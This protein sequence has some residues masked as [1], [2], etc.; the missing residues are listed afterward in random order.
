VS[1]LIKEFYDAIETVDRINN[2]KEKARE[3]INSQKSTIKDFYRE[4]IYALERKRDEELSDLDE[5]KEAQLTALESKGSSFYATITKMERIIKFIHLYVSQGPV[6]TAEVPT[7]SYSTNRD[8]EGNYL[9]GSDRR[10]VIVKPVETIRNDQYNQIHLYII[11]NKKPVNKFSLVIRGNCSLQG[12]DSW[13]R[14]WGRIAIALKD[15]PS[16]K[17]LLGYMKRN[18]G[19]IK[20]KIDMVLLDQLQAEYETSVA[21][22]ARPVWKTFYFERRMYHY[23][24]GVTI[25][26]YKDYQ[27]LYAQSKEN[28]KDLPLL[29]GTVQSDEGKH[30]LEFL[31]K[32]Y[33][34]SPEHGKSSPQMFEG[35]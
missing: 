8:D 19:K 26:E 14:S 9:F 28:F 24:H 23:K 34:N 31:L 12:D 5:K 16:E 32:S 1:N 25:G 33:R 2:E 7:V 17:V 21:L 27:A 11:P 10:E 18:L 15:A 35:V 30:A 6:I 13:G 20:G 3:A 4:A 29:I 22:F